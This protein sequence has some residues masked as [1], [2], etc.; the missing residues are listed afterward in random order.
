MKIYH[1]KDVQYSLAY[2]QSFTEQGFHRAKNF[3]QHMLKKGVPAN[4]M[5]LIF[6]PDGF[7]CHDSQANGQR[8]VIKQSPAGDK[9]YWVKKGK[10]IDN[11]LISTVIFALFLL[12][13]FTQI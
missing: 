7:I 10:E 13:C 4:S 5:Q 8:L 2:G 9:K 12:I 3:I 6:C 1:Y 11:K